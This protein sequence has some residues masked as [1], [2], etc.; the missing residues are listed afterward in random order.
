MWRRHLGLVP[1]AETA[2]LGPRS[3][4]PC[5][6]KPPT[7]PDIIRK[8]GPKM[9]SWKLKPIS[10]DQ[11]ENN[12]V[13]WYSATNVSNHFQL[14]GV[15]ALCEFHYC[16]FHYCGFS[17]LSRYILSKTEF[18]CIK[19]NYNCGVVGRFE[20]AS[21]RQQ[22]ESCHRCGPKKVPAQTAKITKRHVTFIFFFKF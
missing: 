6:N 7:F 12:A 19:P 9:S 21:E 5:E 16:E 13:Q 4:L 2:C 18:D 8:L 20:S 17:K 11:I 3:E 10:L 14:Q 22:A 1:N 15:L